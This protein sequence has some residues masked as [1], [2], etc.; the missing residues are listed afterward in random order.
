MSVIA[1]LLGVLGS[2]HRWTVSGVENYDIDLGGNR[3]RWNGYPT[4]FMQVIYNHGG[5]DPGVV[6]Y[7]IGNPGAAV[8]VTGSPGSTPGHWDLYFSGPLL[9]GPFVVH[10]AN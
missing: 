6:F 1:P 7:P 8:T 4:V 3:Y 10:S 9:N 5:Y 2:G